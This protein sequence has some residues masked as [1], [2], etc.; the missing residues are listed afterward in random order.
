MLLHKQ[1]M[2]AGNGHLGQVG[3]NGSEC[4]VFRSAEEVRE[5]SLVNAIVVD[6]LVMESRGA[7]E[8]VRPESMEELGAYARIGR[9]RPV[10]GKPLREG[11]VADAEAEAFLDV[12]RN[13]LP[14]LTLVVA[15]EGIKDDG[16]R[17][18][19]AFGDLRSKDAVAVMAAPELDGFELL[20][21]FA[22][23]G[24]AGAPAVEAALA[25]LADETSRRVGHGFFVP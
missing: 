3:F 7:D 24:D 4:S 2:R 6:L 14:G 17:E 21:A 23:A 20:V 8:L 1:G 12:G 16:Q 18:G 5:L 25:L 15:Y 22:F 10:L 13:T 11:P 19:F 9:Q